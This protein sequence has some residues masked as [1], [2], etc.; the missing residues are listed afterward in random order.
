MFLVAFYPSHLWHAS[1]EK[2]LDGS[3]PLSLWQMSVKM[4]R[5][6][7]PRGFF[8]G[9]TPCL[10]RVTPHSAAMFVLYEKFLTVFT[11]IQAQLK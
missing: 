4:M 3:A 6:E 2:P 11:S 8:K 5:H 9:L 1:Q 10:L 7:G